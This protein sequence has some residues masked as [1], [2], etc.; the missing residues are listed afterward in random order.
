MKLKMPVPLC[1]PNVHVENFYLGYM[2]PWESVA[3]KT[4]ENLWRL[5]FKFTNC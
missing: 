4:I 2:L 3:K 1:E 5:L